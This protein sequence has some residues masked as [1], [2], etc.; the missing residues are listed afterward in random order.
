MGITERRERAR[1]ETR[2]LILDAAREMFAAD[3]YE[4]V[5]LRKIAERVE[6]SPAAIYLH[7]ADKEA[8]FAELVAHDMVAFGARLLKLRKVAAP[9]ER[10]RKAGQAYTDFALELP[11]HYRLLFMNVRPHDTAPPADGEVAASAVYGFIRETVEEAIAQGLLRPGLDDADAVAQ[12]VWAG[13]HGMA[14]L[15]I[16]LCVNKRAIA[17]RPVRERARL[18]VEVLIE[19][20]ARPTPPQKKR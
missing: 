8:L 17:W 13:V 11:N 20:L 19:G 18:M 6:Y 16:A 14:S 5:T 12:T 10:L 7:F 4:A 15:H 9:M 3:G 2:T 1:Q